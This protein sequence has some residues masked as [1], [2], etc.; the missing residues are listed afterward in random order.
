MAHSLITIG[1]HLECAIQAEMVVGLELALIERKQSRRFRHKCHHMQESYER[2]R[3]CAKVKG[4]VELKIEKPRV[5]TFS[6]DFPKLPHS[7]PNSL[8]A[9][10][11]LGLRHV[12]VGKQIKE[13]C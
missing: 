3:K 1:V 10:V 2:V 4:R 7:N 11:H 9:N 13:L 6:Y 8:G 5:K 12:Q